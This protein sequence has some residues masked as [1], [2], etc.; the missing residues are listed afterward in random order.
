MFRNYLKISLRNLLKYKQSSL[1][2]VLGLS[3]GLACCILCYLHIEYELSYDKFHTHTKNLYR[4]V[5]GNPNESEYW[6]KVAA[7]MPLKFKSEIPEIKEFTRLAPVTYNPNVLVQYQDKTFFEPYFMMADPAFFTMFSFPEVK[8]DAKKALQDLNTVV[9]TE[10][11][12]KKIF[13]TE[14]PIGKVIHLKEENEFSFQVGAIVADPPNQSHFRFDYLISFENLDR[15]LGKKFSTFWGA[16]NFYAYVLLNEKASAK[17]AERKIQASKEMLPDSQEVTFE[18]VFLQPID[19]IHFQASRGNQLPS[20]D[21]RYIYV[22][23]TI[24]LSLL[25]VACINYINL[26]IALSIKRIKEIGV[27]KAIGASR[28]QLI[29]QFINEGIVTTFMALAIALIFLEVSLPWIN[30][31]FDS[32]IHTNYFDSQFLI[33][34]LGTSLLVGLLAGSYLAFYVNGFKT[35]SILKGSVQSRAK[36]I[37]LQKTLVFVQF[38]ISAVLI[39]CSLIIS[40]QMNFLQ[41]KNLGFNHDQV[42]TAALGSTITPHQVEQLKNQLKQSANVIDVAASSFTPGKAN[43]NQTVWWEGQTEPVSMFIISVDKDFL[44]TMQINLLEGDLEKI[45]N[46]GTEQYILNKSAIDLI[47]WQKGAGQLFSPFGEEYKQPVTAV[48][49]NFN[50]MSLHHEI[51]PL[52]L[53]ISDDFKLNQLSIRVTGSNLSES[54]ASVE[55]TYKEVLGDIPFEYAFMDDT[56]GQ[57]YKSETRVKRIV[58]G[59]TV[60]AVFF[61]LFGVYGLISFSIENKTKEIAIRKVLGISPNELLVLFSKTYYQLMAVAFLVSI[62][63]VWKVMNLWLSNFNYRVNIEPLWFVLAFASVLIAITC[64]GLIKYFSV[65]HVNPAQALKHE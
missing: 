25:I 18:S 19:K 29:F 6:T 33:F 46:T 65:Q 24:A 54:V 8:G 47:G 40:R 11:I 61:A 64:I 13:G 59:L 10:S 4:L 34:V 2:N 5:A 30:T 35:A 44:R 45:E 49:E 22:F 52:V 63:I 37:G 39:V 31:L 20:Y 17:E 14:D 57:L 42:I 3:L 15:V 16:Y 9:L 7:P 53:V 48:V 55:Q 50:F 38:T 58:S 41:Q 32:S 36:G 60:V 28:K 23:I 27:R 26:S 1:L 56:I 51:A 12:A 43:W 62:P 21:K